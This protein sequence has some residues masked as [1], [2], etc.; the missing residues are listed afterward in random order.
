MITSGD[1][2]IKPSEHIKQIRDEK[3]GLTPTGDFRPNPL[4]HDLHRA[5]GEL[6]HGLYQKDIHFL[7]ELIQNAEDNQYGHGI[8]PELDFI[9]LDTD[10]THTVGASGALLVVNNEVGFRPDHVTALCSVGDSTKKKQ[11]GYIGEKSIGFKSVFAISAQPHIFSSGYQF[12]FQEQPD[13][14]AGIG[15]IIPYWVSDI[16]DDV[17]SHQ[18]KTC[19]VLPLKESKRTEIFQQLEMVAPE[20]ILFLRTLRQIYIHGGEGRTMRVLRHD[21][22]KPFVTVDDGRNP[23]DYWVMDTD[24][25]IPPESQDEKRDGLSQRTVSVA[26]PLKT[27]KLPD[28]RVFAFL[29]TEVASGLPFLVNADFILSASR[30]RIQ[31][32]RPWNRWLRDCI[33]PTFLDAF[34][35]LVQDARYRFEAYASIPLVSDV[36]DFFFAPIIQPIL[37]AL[38]HKAVVWVEHHSTPL[39]P[40]HV[41]TVS[42]NFRKLL[43]AASSLPKQLQKTPLVHPTIQRHQKRLRA[44]GVNDLSIDEIITC[45]SDEAWLDQQTPAWFVDVYQYLSGEGWATSERLCAIPCL[46]IEGGQRTSARRQAPFFPSPTAQTVADLC[47]DVAPEFGVVFLDKHLDVLIRDSPALMR[48]LADTF[49]VWELTI[50]SYCRDLAQRLNANRTHVTKPDLIRLDGVP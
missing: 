16:P 46:L 28:R 18:R 37:N 40:T 11:D 38:K 20:T 33:V 23:V 12:R 14:Q 35:H 48:W 32:D 47:A 22:Q 39:R 24:F 6:S 2:R 25:E 19:I 21:A 44:I 4:S 17:R 34:T 1:Y 43:E 36:Q 15:Y 10:P 31:V 30:E 29:P 42:P 13:T 5:V 27:K 45:L 41:R 50:A 8:I 3:F 7:L 49:D 9:L 26:L